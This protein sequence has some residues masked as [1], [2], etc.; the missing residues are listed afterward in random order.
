MIMTSMELKL[1]FGKVGVWLG[2]L[3]W[4]PAATARTAAS[5]IEA[6]GYGSLWISEAPTGKEAFTNAAILLAATD[7]ITVATGVANIW[8]RDPVA[9]NA[10]ANALA[11]AYPGRFVLGMGVSHAAQVDHR[12]HRYTKPLAAM[13]CYLAT[14]ADAQY[15][16]PRPAAPVPWLLGALR[17][18][19]LE[20]A[21]DQ[22][23]GAH[24]LLV[25]PEHTALARATMGPGPVLVPQQ[26][27]LLGTNAATARALGRR[28]L[29]FYLGLPNYVNH[30][31]ALGFTDRD[32][33]GGGSDQLVDR[34]VAWGDVDAIEA[35]VA[36]HLDAGADH[37]AVQPIGAGRVLGLDQLTELAP[38]LI[39]TADHPDR[40]PNREAGITGPVPLDRA[41]RR[42]PRPWH[43]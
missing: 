9:T 15:E 40:S 8:A 24:C 31:R 42:P 22:A 21:R 11:E 18:R 6:L 34:L 26:A 5:A 12:G 23:A 27:V 10:A 41:G 7:R 38:A 37:V 33:T 14:M 35:R 2:A 29:S 32:V 16:G 36:A 43:R 1:R 20:L 19:M 3:G 39:A 28:Y 17:P 13:R 25:P 4:Q 30:L